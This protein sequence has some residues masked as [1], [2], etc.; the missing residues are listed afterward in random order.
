MT[1]FGTIGIFVRFIPLPSGTVAFFRGFIG[2]A[3]LI[4]AMLL[5]KR[6]PDFKAVKKNL[7]VLTV[8]GVFIGLNW[9]MLFEAYR[10]TAIPTA[11]LCYY[12]SPTFVVLLAPVFL[13]EKFSLKKTLCSFTALLGMVFVT[14][15]F[16]SGE[17]TE[18]SF[19]GILFALGAA[20]LYAGVT[21]LNRKL[22]DISGND[23]TVFQ[24]IAA[25]AVM[26]PYMLFEDVPQEGF[27]ALSLIL[28]LTVGIIH[29]GIAYSLYIGSIKNLSAQTVAIFGY[30]DPVVSLI[31]SAVVLNEK[32][33]IFGYIGAVLIIG[34]AVF[35]ETD[36]KKARTPKQSTD[37]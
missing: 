12:M 5:K 25:T 3:F 30:I 22:K 34:S 13:K 8:S 15:V 27:T 37:K 19:S 32:L 17:K 11:T 14:G 4:C 29:T 2:V 16:S 7:A 21:M 23:S 9:I 24:L 6:K 10:R 18:L 1:I 36:T 33:D 28:L 35:S 20:A 31:L 26:L